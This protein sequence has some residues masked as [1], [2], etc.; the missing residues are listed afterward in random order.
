MQYFELIV[1]LLF[2]LA[3]LDLTV[4]VSNDAVNFLNSAIG[5][6]VANRRVILLIA[7]LGVL[8][9]SLFSSGIMEVA[10]KGIFNP[11]MFVF[12]DVMIIF[13]AVMLADVLLLDVFNTFGL[14]TSTTVSIVFELLGASLAVALI[15]VTGNPDAG[16]II[17]YVNWQRATV[18]VGGI[19]LSI[20]V[21]FFLGTLV[22][23]FSRLI[24]TFEERNHTAVIKVGWSAIA[25]T[26]ISFFLLFKGLKGASFISSETYSFVLDN[27]VPFSAAMLAVWTLIMWLL[28]RLKVDI[29]AIVVLGGTFSLAL[30][31]ASND[32]VN[33]I[34][35]PLAGL[36]S[37]QAWTG[38][39]IPADA[40]TMEALAAPVQGNTL[41]LLGAGAVMMATLWLSSKA[42]SVTQTSVNLGRQDDG[43]ERFRPGPLSRGIVR[44]FLTTGEAAARAVPKPWRIGI[45][46]RFARERVRAFDLDRPA[47]DKLRASVN[48]TVASI[49]IVVATSLKLPL[50]TTFVSFMVAMGASLA[51]RAWG[52][53][54]A[55]YRIAGV[56]SVVA[57]WFVTAAAAFLLAALFATLI[58]YFGGYAVAALVIAAV[59]ALVHSYRYHRRRSKIMEMMLAA[60]GAQMDKVAQTLRQHFDEA[61]LRHAEVIDR[62]FRLLIKRKRKGAKKLAASL[63]ADIE[64]TRDTEKEFVRRLN[65]EKPQIE[66]WLMGQL[67]TLA[68]ERDLLQSAAT[69]ADL[70]AEHVLNEHTPPSA[71]VEQSL[72]ALRG[73]F[74]AGFA[75]IAAT[76]RDIAASKRSI[77]SID[78]GVSALTERILEDLYAGDRSTQNTSL[79]LGIALEMR[80]ISRAMARTIT[81]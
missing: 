64:A 43:A 11:E 77:Q 60:N 45:D 22:Q 23:F 48:L 51:D 4:G 7:G 13:L 24:F 74:R 63:R 35:V 65:R 54:S 73:Q 80:D 40:M 34:G 69:L 41:I 21:A 18:I 75:L 53:D 20:I 33:F 71:G 32:L 52:R 81:W 10:R 38:S 56:F 44:T 14:P 55:V 46:E 67:D 62:V 76:T 66:P 42:R 61:L 49:I 25:F 3:V 8:A 78:D 27:V 15:V 36:S 30:A 79:L 58:K 12:A 31:F 28:D 29:L 68:C 26:V 47:F 2:V 6:R 17:D 37:W 1:G 70:A 59:F 5:S 39:G 72:V 57:G 19:G 50:S 16:S 9:G